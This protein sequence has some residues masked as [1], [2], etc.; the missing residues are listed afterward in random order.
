MAEKSYIRHSKYLLWWSEV[1]CKRQMKIN[2]VNN[3]DEKKSDM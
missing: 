3:I 1:Q 2:N